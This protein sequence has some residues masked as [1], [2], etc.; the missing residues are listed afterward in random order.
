M[1]L[2]SHHFAL[3]DSA[4]VRCFQLAAVEARGQRA[5]ASN[6]AFVVGNA[7]A[8]SRHASLRTSCTPTELDA[9]LPQEYF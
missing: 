8:A 5:F 9:A 1:P 2:S 7:S 4:A 6:R 3:T